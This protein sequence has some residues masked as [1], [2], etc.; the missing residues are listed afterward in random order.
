MLEYMEK[1]RSVPRLE[2]CVTIDKPMVLFLG[3]AISDFISG[4]AT[5]LA[6]VMFW[7]SGLAVFAAIFGGVAASWMSREYRQ[8][9]PE[10][11][12]STGAGQW[13]FNECVQFPR[14]LKNNA[15]GF[16]DPKEALWIL[17]ILGRKYLQQLLD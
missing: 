1:Y 10:R 12:C 9:F 11:F 8:R 14:S 2:T 3:L 17:K 4:V 7:D 6:V 5:F 15:S 13:D 16:L